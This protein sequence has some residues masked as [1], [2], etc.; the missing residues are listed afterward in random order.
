[1]KLFSEMIGQE[2]SFK[3]LFKLFLLVSFIQ[4]SCVYEVDSKSENNNDVKECTPCKIEGCQV[5]EDCIAGKF[6]FVLI[7]IRKAKSKG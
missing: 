1:M 5:L 3:M 6:L 4:K 2:E 7:S